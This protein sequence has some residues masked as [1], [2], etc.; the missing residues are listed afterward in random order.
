M[1]RLGGPRGGSRRIMNEW[2]II[3]LGQRSYG[4]GEPHRRGMD[5]PLDVRTLKGQS[6]ACATTQSCSGDHNC[7][8]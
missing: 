3:L 2:L 5:I 8:F 6:R 1:E 7:A 4:K